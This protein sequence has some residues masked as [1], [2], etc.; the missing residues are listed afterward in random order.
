MH[1][2]VQREMGLE[3]LQDSGRDVEAYI[4]QMDGI[5]VQPWRGRAWDPLE[6]E[7]IG[8]V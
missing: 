3:P 6:I 7:K 8:G 1:A 2:L 5:L 4:P